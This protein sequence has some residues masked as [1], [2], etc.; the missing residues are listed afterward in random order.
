MKYIYIIGFSLIYSFVLNLV[1]FKKNHLQTMETKYYSILLIVNLIGLIGEILCSIVGFTFPE[2]SP[3][4]HFFTKTF[5]STLT[6][7]TIMMSLYI[8]S[9]CLSDKESIFDKVKK[10]SLAFLIFSIFVIFALPITT[11]VGF[12]TGPSC[13]YVYNVGTVLITIS[14]I[15]TLVCF[16]K[17]DITKAIPFFAFTFFNIIIVS[18][19]FIISCTSDKIWWI[20][21]NKII[22]R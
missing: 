13:D 9:L 2:N 16:K 17:I 14:I 1:Y 5:M 11:A 18:I 19:F 12:A 7:F 10:F 4:S 15:T 6:C 20:T 3:I 21:I 22:T 8:Y